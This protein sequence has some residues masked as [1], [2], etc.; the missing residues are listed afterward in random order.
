MGYIN[1]FLINMH[2]ITPPKFIRFLYLSIDLV[3]AK[4]IRKY[5]IYNPPRDK[6]EGENGDL[7]SGVLLP[8]I[9]IYLA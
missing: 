2:F 3:K 9:Y 6:R 4:K 7:S 5:F 8:L 1:D